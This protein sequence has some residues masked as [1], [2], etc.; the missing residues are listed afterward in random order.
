MEE[1]ETKTTCAE[2]IGQELEECLEELLPNVSTWSVLKC[3]RY[4]ESRGPHTS[5][6]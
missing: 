1:T 5:D 6:R 4:P 3:A 2:R